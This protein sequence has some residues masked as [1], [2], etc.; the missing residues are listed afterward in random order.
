MLFPAW[1]RS[2]HRLRLFTRRGEQGIQIRKRSPCSTVFQLGIGDVIEL[3]LCRASTL[4]HKKDIT[5]VRA[6]AY[7][8]VAAFAIDRID[9]P[10]L[11][12]LAVIDVQIPEA[13][14]S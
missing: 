6:P 12:N 1:N 9:F 7:V 5:L 2:Q 3:D 10:A 11:A 8:A 13:I 4:E 14:V